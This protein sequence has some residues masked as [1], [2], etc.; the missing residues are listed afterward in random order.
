VILADLVLRNTTVQ[1]KE[2]LS[3]KIT[4]YT[5]LL[6]DYTEAG[7][8]ILMKVILRTFSFYVSVLSKG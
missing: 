2:N 1:Y 3:I 7:L 5:I 6:A 8:Q 4:K